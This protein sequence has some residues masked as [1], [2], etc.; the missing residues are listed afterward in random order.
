VQASFNEVNQAQQERDRAINIAR[1]EYNKKVPRTKGEADQK[2]AEA[3]G[4]ATKR[5]NE[6][7]GDADRFSALFQEYAKAPAITRER[8]YLERMKEVLPNIK[9]KIIID[10][11]AANTPLPLL[12]LG[13]QNPILKGNR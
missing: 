5:I 4:Q 10:G 1:G 12:H 8:L 13:E 7:T 3:E 2:I 11:S 6:A 9:S